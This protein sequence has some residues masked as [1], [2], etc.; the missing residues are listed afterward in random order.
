MGEGGSVESRKGRPAELTLEAGLKKVGG[1]FEKGG[2]QGH[3]VALYFALGELRIVPRGE[4]VMG[5]AGEIEGRYSEQRVC[6]TQ[7]LLSKLA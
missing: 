4:G 6:P 3:R 1:A 7:I 2:L 5:L